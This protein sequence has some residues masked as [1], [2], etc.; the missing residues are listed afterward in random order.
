MTAILDH[1]G[2]NVSDL[3]LSLN[4]YC[5]H[6]GFSEQKRF[7]AS[8]S[9]DGLLGLTGVNAQIVFLENDVVRLELKE[10][11]SPPNTNVHSSSSIHDT[12]LIHLCFQVED[13]DDW[14]S[15]LSDD[16]KFISPPLYVD[17]GAKIANLH[18]PDGNII[19]LVERP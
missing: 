14:Y 7:K 12:G 11:S 16:I 19:E 17:S 8:D 15:K 3:E 4:F 1:I 6:F 10:Y 13:I 5:T 9:Q 18:D 2:L